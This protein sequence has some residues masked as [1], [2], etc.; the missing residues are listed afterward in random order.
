MEHSA[1]AL[2]IH[3]L[4]GRIVDVNQMACE[5]LGYSRDEL[6]Q[7]SVTDIYP[8]SPRDGASEWRSMVLGV[9]VTLMSYHQRKDRT[10]FPTEVNISTFDLQENRLVL[11]LARD[12]TQ[13]QA[14]ET[15]RRELAVLEERN[16]LAR[17][18][19]DSVTQALYSASF[20]SEAGDLD[21]VR[22]YLGRLGDSCQQ[23][24]KEMRLLVFQLRPS[25]LEKEG[26]VGAL[27]QRLDAVEKRAGVEARVV[28]GQIP[29][30]PPRW[31]EDP[32]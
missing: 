30:L 3:D 7:S 9:P 19:H 2:F 20:M 26:L 11:A 17:E 4:Q 27:R 24:L 13:R 5:S 32:H 22:R 21:R 6:L 18:L 1:D 14:M 29:D 31:E 25:V 10:T 28:F 15:A 16:R 8:L 23:A 12:V